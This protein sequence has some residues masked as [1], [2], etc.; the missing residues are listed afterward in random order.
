MTLPPFRWAAKIWLSD[1]KDEWLNYYDASATCSEEGLRITII[2]LRLNEAYTLAKP[3][4]ITRVS[5][6]LYELWKSKETADIEST[7]F[8]VIFIRHSKHETPE[9]HLNHNSSVRMIVGVGLLGSEL[10]DEL[11]YSFNS[12]LSIQLQSEP[13]PDRT[14]DII[15]GF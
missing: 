14:S 3:E 5:D 11:Q 8:D 12:L 4:V 7:K 15:E 1:G 2:V 13:A 9:I 6:D 10:G